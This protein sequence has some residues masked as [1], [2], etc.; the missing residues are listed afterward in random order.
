M[1]CLALVCGVFLSFL[2]T[3]AGAAPTGSETPANRVD[4]GPTEIVAEAEGGNRRTAEVP[5]GV[6]KAE[7][8]KAIG[9]ID[10]PSATCYQP[11]PN[12]DECFINWYYLSVSAAP[13]YMI[14]MWV[15]LNSIG[16]V[17][18]YQGF[19]QTSMYVPY[20]MHGRGIKVPCG[21]LVVSDDPTVT[22]DHG[23]TY[24]FTIRARDSGGFKSAN[25]GTIYCPA[26]IP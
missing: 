8:T 21:P 18:I 2:A 22:P 3:T 19:F 12:V 7:A 10:S 24:G 9:F 5:L 14:N 1:R 25:H 26:Y 11:D 4:P 13:D 23:N 20:G 17:A 16:G 6:E 15:I